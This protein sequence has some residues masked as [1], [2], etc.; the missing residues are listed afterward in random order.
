MDGLLL[1]LWSCSLCLGT[2]VVV[3]RETAVD[4]KN[5]TVLSHAKQFHLVEHHSRGLAG[6]GRH[7]GCAI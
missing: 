3:V 5:R 2:E 1:L 4:T 7:V 6:S